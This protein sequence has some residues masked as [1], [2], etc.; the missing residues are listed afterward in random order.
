[1]LTS[2]AVPTATRAHRH[3]REAVARTVRTVGNLP[4]GSVGAL[5]RAVG[6]LSPP[7][8]WPRRGL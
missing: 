1:M 2:A 7:A 8:M 3:W 4:A 5:A 6:V